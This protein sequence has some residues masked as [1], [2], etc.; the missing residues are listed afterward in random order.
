MR[1]RRFINVRGHAQFRDF[2]YSVIDHGGE[3][4]ERNNLGLILFHTKDTKYRLWLLDVTFHYLLRSRFELADMAGD[5]LN[6]GMMKSV[7]EH[8]RCD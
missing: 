3:L 5:I 8:K 6:N 1:G 7:S 2:R 4:E